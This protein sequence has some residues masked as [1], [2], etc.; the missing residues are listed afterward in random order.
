MCYMVRKQACRRPETEPRL[1]SYGHRSRTEYR[2]PEVVHSGCR[3]PIEGQGKLANQTPPYDPLT[4][5]INVA[6]ACKEEGRRLAVRRGHDRVHCC[7]ENE[8]L[9][10]TSVWCRDRPH[11][12]RCANAALGQV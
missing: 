8:P 10:T 11:P 12:R 9:G 3:S 4:G 6:A 5:T 2:D 7:T 1:A